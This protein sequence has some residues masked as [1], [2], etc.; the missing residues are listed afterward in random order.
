MMSPDMWNRFAWPFFKQ[1][2]Q[3]VVE[4]NLI[5]ILHLDA[6]WDREL[7]PQG[8]ILPSGCDIPALV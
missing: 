6:N 5:A 1:L 3:A 4:R 7:G 2:V 8:F